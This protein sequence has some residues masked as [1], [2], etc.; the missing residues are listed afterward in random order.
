MK[1]TT[2]V[3][4]RE[5]DRH[6]IEDLGVPSTLLME[7]ASRALARE[8]ALV[9]S[10]KRAAVFCGGGN[11]G[12]D[13]IGA[14]RRLV[15]LGWEVR[16]FLLS[17]RL[18]EDSAE[19]LRRLRELR[20]DA[21]P[22]SDS[23][24]VKDWLRTCGVVIDAMLG[25]GL[26]R[27]MEGD[28]AKAAAL[29]AECGAKIV[30]ADIASGVDSD[31][32]LVP[33]AAVKADVTV[34]FAAPK[35][36][37]FLEPGCAYSGKVI[38]ADIGIDVPDD[39]RVSAV[40]EIRMPERDQLAHKGNFGKVL[41]IAGSRGYTGAPVLAASAA[42]RS[43]AGL[44]WLG[45]PECVYPPVAASC[46]E[47]M[48]FPL[49]CGEDGAVAKA[50]IPAI[51]ERLEKVDCCLAGPG[52]QNT[53]AT[54]AVVSAILEKARIP[55]VLDAD[56]I[57]AV[58]GNI[59]VL[60]SASNVV[61]TPHAGEFARL[62]GSLADGRIAGAL[63]LAEKTGAAVVLKGHRSVTSFPD[64]DVFVN[65]TGNAGMACGGSGDVLAGMIA[66]LGA[67]FDL[68]KAVPSAVWLHGRAG[69]LAADELGEDFMKPTDIIDCLSGAFRET[70]R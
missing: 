69:D 66:A 34:T 12:G 26:R 64:G 38:T 11:N 31:T 17:D 8:A 35:T 2:G 16:V 46:A 39:S 59:D 10:N 18:S 51:L 3:M 56:G 55:V 40:T 24:K 27:P 32:G 58:S 68:K 7:R 29:M 9:S 14:A 57:N 20:A 21:E 62:G 5:A 23:G 52:L 50:A 36:G 28:Y 42:V 25:T 22:F 67:R 30:S 13:G 60:K 70:Y 65:T 49:P 54:R 48:P 15:L 1:L 37:Q 4:Q 33:G 6:A 53:E 47:I 63:A 61:L 19:M 44:V 45:V 41:I 43:G